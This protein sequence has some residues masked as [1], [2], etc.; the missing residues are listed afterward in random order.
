[1]MPAQYAGGRAAAEPTTGGF[2]IRFAARLIDSLI[3]LVFGFIG[4]FVG[5]I[6]VALTRGPTALAT[7]H[8]LLASPHALLAI[9]SSLLMS[10]VAVSAYHVTSEWIGGATIGK[11]VLGLRVRNTELGRCTLGGAI[12]RTLAYFVDA[13]FFGLVAYLVMKESPRKQRLGDQWGKTVVVEA[14]SLTPDADDVGRIVLGICLGAALWVVI[15]GSQALI[16]AAIL[17]EP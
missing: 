15:A 2:G 1:M 11:L 13:L 16:Q 7:G 5:A 8:N 3:G 14:A 12:I 6:V 17:A 4:G 9:G 10:T